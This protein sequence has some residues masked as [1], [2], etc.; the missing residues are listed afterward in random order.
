MVLIP[1]EIVQWLFGST[2]NF[3]TILTVLAIVGLI[4]LLLTSHKTKSSKHEIEPEDSNDG[5]WLSKAQKKQKTRF[6]YMNEPVLKAAK[7]RQEKE[8]REK[9][10]KERLERYRKNRE[11]KPM[12]YDEWKAAKLAEQAKKDD[13][14]T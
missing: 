1:Y 2:E 14:Q 5:D 8:A 6:D 12:N 13:Q 9:Q 11:G 10:E 7:A 3:F 4:I